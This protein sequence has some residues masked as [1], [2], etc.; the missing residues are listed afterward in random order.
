M[1]DHR[2]RLTSLLAAGLLA[3]CQGGGDGGKGSILRAHI[4]SDLVSS[5]PGMRRDLNTDGVLLH[6]VEGLVASRE[7]G[8]VGPMLASRWT[9]S[10]DRRT[11][12]FVLRPDVHFHNGKPLTGD[13]VLWSFR[14]Y[15]ADGSSWRCKSEFSDKGLARVERMSAPDPHSF[16]IVLDRPAPLLLKTLA[17]AD[18]GGTGIVH[19]DSVSPDGSWRQPIGTGPFR[20]AEWRRN[21]YVDLER[22]ERYRSLPGEPDGNGGGK[23]AL[24]D[25][26]RF[27]VIPDSSSANAALLRGSIDVLDGLATSEMDA[28]RGD[29]HIRILD[30]PS[31]DLYGMLFQVRDP[32]LA[33]SRLRRA[34][35]LSLDVARLTRAATR[36]TGIANSS[37]IPVASPFSTAVERQLIRRN[38]AEARALAKAAGYKGQPISLIASKAPPQMFDAAIIAQAMAREAG[39]NLEIV[40]LDWAT[41]LA[42]YSS[43]NYQAMVFG[44]S[45]R[46]DPSLMYLAFTGDKAEDP[47]K[48]WSTP[49]AIALLRRSQETDD[50]A[51]RQRIFDAM[52]Q[53]FRADAP[54]VMF[55]NS[56]RLAAVRTE[57]HGYRM[58]PA[59]LIRLWNVSVD[60]H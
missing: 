10:P 54:A 46:L 19:R 23:K 25:R 26:I 55:Y 40:P 6:V 37:P 60:R 52:E 43:G 16:E 53:A 17:R 33:D 15:L 30:A 13:D 2:R 8:S 51:Q 32:L 3:A 21:Q 18:C 50:P 29:P 56:R 31:M 36:D 14:R 5:D 57:V 44:Y 22:F 48:V 20:W 38:L 9:V 34:I 35:A 49:Q 58:W 12:H 59:Q 1:P 45:P 24:V 39:I 7:D 4:N 47:R 42:R 27:V 11:Y 41:H 28:L